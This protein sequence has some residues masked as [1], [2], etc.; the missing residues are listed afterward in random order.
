MASKNDILKFIE[1]NDVKFVRL[2]FTDILGRLKNIAITERQ[3]ERALE[4]GIIFDASAIAGFS[5]VESS[6][7]L[8]LPDINTFTIIP[9]R[10]QHGKVA[11]FICDIKNYDG[12]QFIGDPR[13]VLKKSVEKAEKLGYTFN[14]G[15]ECEFFLFHTDSEGRPTAK[16]HDYASYCD[17]AP[18]DLGENCRREICMVLEEMGFEIE[19]LHHENAAGQHEIDFKYSDVLTAADRIMTFRMVVKTI[20]QRNGLHATFMPKPI[21]NAFG[22]GM[23]IN[24]SLSKEGKNLFNAGN[25]SMDISDVAKMFGAGI[26]NHINGIT[27]VANPLV[28][29]YKRFVPGFEAPV[30]IAWSHMNRSPLLRVP[31]PKGE[32]TRL[33]LRSPDSS[34]N[35]YLTLALVLEAGLDGLQK[36]MQIPLPV[37]I[38][39]YSLTAEKEKELGIQR[40]PSN[41]LLAI[42]EMK[43]DPYIKEVLG[44]HIYSKYI[45]AKEAEWAA[46]NNYVHQWEIDNYLTAF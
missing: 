6:D 4:E 5:E 10:P 24:M 35:P 38:N 15:P 1:Q 27:A 14:V 2:Q 33:E 18:M 40:L 20:A 32:A 16:T 42:E 30:H 39:T 11:R 3:V 36:E 12:T 25:G 17:L 9:W 28:N 13:Y 31:A 19:A 37:D 21:F 29:S 23:H 34:C 46:Y 7:M 22:S 43:K 45:A 41:L 44:E 8:L 26:L